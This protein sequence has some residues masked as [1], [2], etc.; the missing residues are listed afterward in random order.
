MLSAAME[1]FS[2]GLALLKVNTFRSYGTV[3]RSCALLKV[4]NFRSYRAVHRRSRAEESESF[5]QLRSNLCGIVR[6]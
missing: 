5:Q 3:F 2:E 6:W 1:Q 4:K